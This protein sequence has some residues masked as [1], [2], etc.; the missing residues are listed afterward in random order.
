MTLK[1]NVSH[2]G[3]QILIIIIFLKHQQNTFKHKQF[4]GTLLSHFNSIHV[5]ARKYERPNE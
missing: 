4:Q 1:F 5:L 3:T 2:P